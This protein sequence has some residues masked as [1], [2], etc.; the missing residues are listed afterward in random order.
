[1]FAKFVL[2]ANSTVWFEIMVVNLLLGNLW[3]ALGKPVWG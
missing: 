1:M 2:A 3:V